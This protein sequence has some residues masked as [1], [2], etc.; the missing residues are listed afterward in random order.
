VEVRSAHGGNEG[1]EAGE[2]GGGEGEAEGEAREAKPAKQAAKPK[3]KAK[4]KALAKAKPAPKAKPA[5]PPRRAATIK[6]RA[7]TQPLRAKTVRS[8]DDLA[9][10]AHGE[11]TQRAL[12]AAWSAWG[13]L[14]PLV[15]THILNPSLMGGPR[16]PGMRQ[17][18]R[19][20]R[21]GGATLLASDGLADPFD[22]P[23]PQDVNGLGLEVYAVT[24]DPLDAIPGSWLWGVVWNT[25]QLAASHGG[26]A[27]LLD[28]LG[29]ITTELYDVAIPEEHRARFV[30]AEG[31]VGVLLGLEDASITARVAGPRSSIRLVNA[32]L[33]TRDELAH[34]LDR[35]DA[36]R[37]ELAQRLRSQG[38]PLI[39]ALG[40][41]SVV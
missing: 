25:A 12:E 10:E 26:L 27:A 4:A 24:S 32:T 33:L 9:R 22:P 5:A 18:Y 39:S 19:V 21:R 6:P 38:A 7:A 36:G 29:V 1:E 34:V 37:Q 2:E 41:A 13:T 30:N 11:A 15:L 31:R 14:D 28:E 16:W 8:P 35:G 3:T 20:V 40:R 17:A 23:G